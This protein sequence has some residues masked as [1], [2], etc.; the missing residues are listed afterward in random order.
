MLR[1]TLTVTPPTNGTISG[2]GIA[3]GTGGND[4]S[5][6]YDYGTV[7]PLTAT[8]DS[9]YTLGGWTGACTGTGACTVTMTAARSVA[10]SFTPTSVSYTLTVTKAGTGSGAVT[11]SP[12]GISCGADCSESYSSGTV[13]TLS[14]AAATGS[15][16]SGWT[17]A[18]SGTGACSVTM[19]AARTVGA[20]FTIAD[21]TAPTVAV[22]APATGSTV[23]G[24]VTVSATASDDVAVAGVQFLL[25]GAL[26]GAEDTTSPYSVAWNTTT[27]TA[28]SHTLTARARDAAGNQ[29]TSAAVPVTVASVVSTGLVAAYGFEEG[30]GTT[31]TDAS[32]LGNTGTITAG[33]WATTGRFG[34]ALSFNGTSSVVTVNDA[35]ALRLTSAMTLEAWVRPTASASWR[36]AMLKETSGGLAYGLYASNTSSRPGGFLRVGSVGS[37]VDATAP[38]AITLNAWT[39]LAATYDGATLRLFVNG[40][41]VTSR[42][43]TGSIVSSTQPLRIGGNQVWGEYFAGL[44]DEIRVY[45]RA[46]SAAEIQTDM[47]TPVSVADTTPPVVSS[48]SAS[49]GGNSTATVQ[50]LTNEPATSV[51]RYGTRAGEPHADGFGRPAA[52][53]PRG[54]A[55]RARR[56]HHVLLSGDLRR[57]GRGTRRAP[58]WAASR[59][60]PTPPPRRSAWWP[61]WAARGCTRA[62]P[63]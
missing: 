8:P 3:C 36:C 51:V 35:A 63:T 2:T 21:T 33:T 23:S 59:R 16:F 56:G 34:K 32:G 26:L 60:P 11:S 6:A 17:G 4:C 18:C 25:D 55:E 29:A 50:W 49:V 31:T 58:R 53:C 15:G 62:A 1:Y 24:T 30:S 5:E 44:I 37:D 61:R 52:D 48:V 19:T 10:A 12:A 54:P 7:V 40:T 13:V 28:G 27:A 47:N 42:A 45:N 38:S 41:Q 46:L 9:G 57:R 14:A 39:H 20:T 22:T 43:L